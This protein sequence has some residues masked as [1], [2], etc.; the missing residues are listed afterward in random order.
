MRHMRD[1]QMEIFGGKVNTIA[2]NK[3]RMKLERNFNSF[4][5]PFKYHK[6]LAVHYLKDD[7]LVWW[8][9]VVEGVWGD[10]SLPGQIF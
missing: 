1:M 4:R 5:C 2:T 10:M 9:R 8:E 7:A 3:W 6:D